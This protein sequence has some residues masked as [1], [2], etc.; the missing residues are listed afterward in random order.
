M[1][2]FLI[3]VFILAAFVIGFALGRVTAKPTEGIDGYL[4]VNLTEGRAPE[5]YLALE[6]DG[7]IQE[8]A[9]K[10]YA[11]FKVIREKRS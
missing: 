2:Y 7:R 5:F 8:I 11:V 6:D 9:S 4:K 10:P 3:F 1:E